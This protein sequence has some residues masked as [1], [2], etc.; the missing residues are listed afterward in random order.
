MVDELMVP[1]KMFLSSREVALVFNVSL[2][3]VQKHA[4]RGTKLFPRGYY[5][6]EGKRPLLRFRIEDVK[7]CIQ[8]HKIKEEQDEC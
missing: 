7:K 3:T 4:K 8:N 6:G 1:K 2:R 5:I